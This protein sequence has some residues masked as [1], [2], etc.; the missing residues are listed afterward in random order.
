MKKTFAL[1]IAFT[2]LVSCLLITL[3]AAAENEKNIYPDGKF[4]FSDKNITYNG[5][6]VKKF[7]GMHG[8]WQSSFTVT[9]TGT[10][11]AARA[12]EQSDYCIEIDGQ[13]PFRKTIYI[14]TPVATQLPDGEHTAVFTL[15]TSKG[16]SISGFIIDENACTL[17]NKILPQIEFIGDSITEGMGPANENDGVRDFLMSY[18]YSCTRELGWRQSTVAKAG[19]RL[20]NAQNLSGMTTYYNYWNYGDEKTEWDTKEYV[21]NYVCVNLGTNDKV[22]DKTFAEEYKS[23][24]STLRVYY[25]DAVIFAIIP[26]A[27]ARNASITEA[28][29]AISKND[30][31]TVLVNTRAWGFLSSDD[32]I[33]NGL[34]SQADGVHLTK[35]GADI[36]GKKLAEFIKAYAEEH[37]TA[38]PAATETQTKAQT[39]SPMQTNNAA[40]QPTNAA[41]N[42]TGEQNESVLFKA[43]VIAGITVA[44]AGGIV[45]CIII[46]K[47]QRGNRHGE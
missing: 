40:I 31:K 41:E 22:D 32:P 26:F 39:N 35:K 12:P 44:A 15:A 29:R 34:A 2:M 19:I 43:F 30:E 27:G 28:V 47:K 16:G 25:P 36:A 11:L 42:S 38:T 23:F 14:N 3:N 37:G 8:G 13:E 5:R 7:N 1:L 9:F 45:L 18:A 33:K 24:L 20:C 6:W 4:L 17:P 21:P 46:K 10:S